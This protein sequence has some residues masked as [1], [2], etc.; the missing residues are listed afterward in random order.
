M[1]HLCK[2]RRENHDPPTP[3]A[4]NSVKGKCKKASE[5]KRAKGR[6]R[7]LQKRRRERHSSTQTI[8]KFKIV[9]DFAPRADAVVP[10]T[11]HEG[12][13]QAAYLG[14]TCDS[15]R[16]VVAPKKRRERVR[17]NKPE[18]TY[19]TGT[20]QERRDTG[21]MGQK[22]WVGSID[23]RPRAGPRKDERRN[24]KKLNNLNGDGGD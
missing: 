6:K 16:G 22:L 11:W 1:G 14:E 23:G 13:E 24:K 18:P 7:N 15:P 9:W 10:A 17:T 12:T 20:H 21:R 4:D 2:T 19:Q 3:C 8:S 5:S